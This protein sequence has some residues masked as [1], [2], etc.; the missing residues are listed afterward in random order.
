MEESMNAVIEQLRGVKK[1]LQVFNFLLI[2]LPLLLLKL[3]GIVTWPWVVV[4]L[5]IIAIVGTFGIMLLAIV[6]VGLFSSK[7]ETE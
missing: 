1:Q 7:K 5:P 6:V 3:Y 2:Q 4:A